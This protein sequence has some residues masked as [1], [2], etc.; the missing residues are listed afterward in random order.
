MIP[1]VRVQWGINIH[2]DKLKYACWTACSVVSHSLWPCGLQ[3]ARL[4]YLW[5]LLGKNTGVG[6]HF[7]LHFL[8]NP[9]IKPTSPAYGVLLAPVTEVASWAER[10]GQGFTAGKRQGPPHLPCWAEG[11]RATG[12]PSKGLRASTAPA[13]GSPWRPGSP[14][15]TLSPLRCEG[16]PPEGAWWP[17]PPL[18]G[19]C[20]PVGPLCWPTAGTRPSWGASHPGWGCHHTSPSAGTHPRTPPGRCDWSQRKWI[21]PCRGC[22]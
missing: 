10:R 3:S 6:C 9:G 7:L 21:W 8:P 11:S 15:S 14:G 5:N 17:S 22:R 19:R 13:A 1:Q 2:F 4:L 16:C 12:G 20:S 18:R